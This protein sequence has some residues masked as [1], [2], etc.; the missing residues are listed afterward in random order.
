M[1]KLCKRC[2]GTKDESEYFPD[3]RFPNVCKYCF[4]D[5]E[6]YHYIVPDWAKQ[7]RGMKVEEKLQIIRDMMD[8][9]KRRI[10]AKELAEARLL[11]WT[12]V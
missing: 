8:E 11:E 9:T 10:N 4:T 3:S 1:S 7:L 2:Q 5:R 12:S 6:L